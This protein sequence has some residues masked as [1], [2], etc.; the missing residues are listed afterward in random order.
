MNKSTINNFAKLLFYIFIMSVEQLNTCPSPSVTNPLQVTGFE[1]KITSIPEMSFWIKNATIPNISLQETLQS[2]PFENIPH[3]GDK[4][5]VGQLQIT[6]TVD[7]KMN[8]YQAL[9][10]W[11]R[12]TGFA[13]SYDDL[14]VWRSR[15]LDSSTLGVDSDYA[16]TSDAHLSIK[17]VNQQTVR[18]ITFKD[19]WITELGGLQLTDEASE[20]TYVTCDA[21]FRFKG[22]FHLSESVDNTSV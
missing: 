6:F 1:F 14:R 10:D 11:I 5:E 4:V 22:M 18:V 12:L 2:T 15:Q 8:N 13:E 21:T 19:L 7:E 20:T 17:G 9:Y 3:I 16:L